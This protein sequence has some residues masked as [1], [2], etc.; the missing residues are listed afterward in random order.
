[1]QTFLWH[2]YETFG[3]DPRRDRPAQFAALRTTPE[4][5]PVGDPVAFYC[6]PARDV[7][8]RV[9]A[10]A[11]VDGLAPPEKVPPARRKPKS[12]AADGQA[13]CGHAGEALYPTWLLPEPLCLEVRAN[14]PHYQGKPVHRLVRMYRV[15][16]GW[17]EAGRS[18]RRDYYI[19][20]SEVAGLVWIYRDRLPSL[21]AQ[22][23]GWYLHGRFG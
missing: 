4:L 16:T 20:R 17:W 21:Q 18:V 13:A 14:R 12:K 2:D 8:P 1:M 15:E 11:V 3:A 6:R 7:L 5:E 9:K 22:A 19:A 10:P 23:S